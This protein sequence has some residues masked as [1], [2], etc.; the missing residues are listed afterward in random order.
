MSKNGFENW[1]RKSHG[2]A[3]AVWASFLLFL[4]LLL[5]APAGHAQSSAAGKGP[6]MPER[7]LDR[8]EFRTSSGQVARS[9]II[10]VKP[11][12]G[13]SEQR[14]EQIARSF[15]GQTAGKLPVIGVFEIRVPPQAEEA[16]LRAMSRRPEIEF[17]EL[18]VLVGP[19]GTI[20]NDP[21]Y[22]SAWHLPKIDAPTA[23]SI[24]KGDGVV[25]AIL[26]TG[27]DATHP[28]LHGKLVQ[29]WNS[30]SQS[31]DVS[32]VH[33]HGT[34]VAGIVGA[35]T[36]NGTGVAAVGWNAKIMPIRVTN[37]SD[38]WAS[39]SDMANGLTWA[40][41]NGAQVANMSYESWRSSTV[42]SAAK[43]L[44][45]RGGIAF[46]A[47]GN[48]G[49][50][51]GSAGA[52]NIIVVSATNSSDAITSWSNFGRF[53]DL[54]APGQ[55]IVTTN[56][57]GNYW[58]GWGT[59]YATPI[60]AGAAALVMSA[61]PMLT[62]AEV[63][64]ILFDSAEDLGAN[65]WDRQYGWGRLNAG[66]AVSMVWSVETDREPPE[67]AFVNPTQDEVITGETLLVKVSA[68]DN[69]EVVRVD[70]YA[71]GSK[72]GSS[73]QAPFE[74]LWDTT[75]AAGGSVRLFA[76]ARDAVGNVGGDAV[77]V[78]VQ[79]AVIEPE[80]ALVP[81]PEPEPAPVPEPEPEPAPSLTLS[82]SSSNQGNVWTAVVTLSGPPGGATAGT[83]NHGRNNFGGCTI[84]A[85]QQSCSFEL[86][87][88]RKN[89][90]SV[91]YSDTAN[92]LSI[93]IGKP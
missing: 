36:S 66:R 72:V 7:A 15:G 19:D 50:D 75:K 29:G 89:I 45:D 38:G 56:R 4:L 59:S 14:L 11:R 2:A 22:G 1:D 31:S 93:T 91:T 69:S 85:G 81:E 54:S 40:A 44:R 39:W 76:E 68:S 55:D 60:A 49:A 42:N 79:H 20:P 18:D 73:S 64:Q 12:A 58:L 65:G 35:A 30:A 24:S 8:G 23:W 25:I 21:H 87:G 74:F 27:I 13:V 47:A 84:A 16:V 9:G 82:G 3:Q 61:N 10:L 37:R 86:G 71:D 52:S 57:G 51:D 32:D 41:N 46:A 62:P 63:Q 83:W 48:S 70:L 92:K 6:G 67:V 5:A 88:I 43:Y 33:G 78:N 80:P 90:G 17:V 26:D 53:V 77:D 28:D 34:R